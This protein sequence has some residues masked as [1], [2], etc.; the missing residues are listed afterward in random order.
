MTAQQYGIILAILTGAVTVLKGDKVWEFL[1]HVFSLMFM[2]KKRL[3]QE[4]VALRKE[5]TSLRRR[6]RKLEKAI[7]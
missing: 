5:N 4:N 3:K 1:K 6:V 7:K 2:G